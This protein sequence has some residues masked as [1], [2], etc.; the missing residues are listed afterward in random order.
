[1][2]MHLAWRLVALRVIAA[3]LGKGMKRND[4]AAEIRAM[5]RLK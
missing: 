2:L 3:A 5:T 4:S 1:M